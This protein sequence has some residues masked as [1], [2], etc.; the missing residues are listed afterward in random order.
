MQVCGCIRQQ[1]YALPAADQQLFPYMISRLP[2]T[3]DTV[4]G[5][6]WRSLICA[7]FIGDRRP[8][9]NG[10][11]CSAGS[12]LMGDDGFADTSFRKKKKTP[13]RMHRKA[14]VVDEP[15]S[16]QWRGRGSR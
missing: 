11:I 1:Q 14:P 6:G 16:K 2:V 9:Q 5:M 3:T 7:G 12:A 15:L 8:A 4:S 10:E 13:V